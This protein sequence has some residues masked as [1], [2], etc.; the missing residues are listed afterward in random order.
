MELEHKS[1]SPKERSIHVIHDI[2]G[3][4]NDPREP[5]DMVQ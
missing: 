3:Q 2:G 1:E 4:N 5:L